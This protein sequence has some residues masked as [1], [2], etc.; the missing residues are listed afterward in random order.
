MEVDEGRTMAD[1][2]AASMKLVG[3]DPALDFVN[4]VGS[5]IPAT[6]GP[7][8]K[9]AKDKLR[10]YRD[11]VL[12]ARHAGLLDETGERELL[13]AAE[14]RPRDGARVLSRAA[15]F[16]EA[17]YR[18]LRAVMARRRP[19]PADVAAVNAEVAAA[20][21]RERLVP[22]DAGL[23]WEPEPA[24]GEGLDTILRPIAAAAAA[25]LTSDELARL[26]ECPGAACGWLFLDRSRNR[27]RQWCTM[28]D[29][30]NVSKVRRFRQRARRAAKRSAAARRQ[31]EVR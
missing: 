22:G 31:K 11:L 21:A 29:C 13:R 2:L 9:V 5:R 28:E 15:R 14:R 4:T 16:R 12:W 18:V 7:G 17:L 6:A 1:S 10:D 8:S 26:R 19:E 27:S 25:L 30:G 20:R 3:G 23:R 24:R